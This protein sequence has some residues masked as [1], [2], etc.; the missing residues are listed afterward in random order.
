M[1]K[2]YGGAEENRTPDLFDANEALYQLSYSPVNRAERYHA[3]QGRAHRLFAHNPP[4]AQVAN[5]FFLRLRYDVAHRP[6]LGHQPRGF[7]GSYPLK[8][9]RS[10]RLGLPPARELTGPATPFTGPHGLAAQDDR[11][12]QR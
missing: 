8:V 3:I 2:A 6:L 1:H 9:V 11:V 5:F 12:G 10:L 7:R 4:P